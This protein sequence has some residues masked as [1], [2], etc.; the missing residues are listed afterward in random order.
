MRHISLFSGAG[1]SEWTAALL[2][3]ETV[4]YVEQDEYCQRAIRAR[5]ADGLF[6]AAPIFDD[7]RAVDWS[8]WAGRADIITA[9]F[10]CQPFSVAGSGKA[11][12]DPR[13]LW[14][15]TLRSIREVEPVF[16]FLENVPGLLAGS[17]GYFGTVLGELASIGFDAEWS[18]LSAKAA[19]APHKRK[20]L[21]VL[22]T[23]PDRFN[24][25]HTERWNRRERSA[26][27][28]ADASDDG[29]AQLVAYTNGE[30]ELQPQGAEQ[31]KRRRAGDGGESRAWCWP[32]EPG[33]G[34]AFDGL[35]LR[36]YGDLISNE[37][38]TYITEALRNVWENDAAQEV[39]E[40]STRRLGLLQAEDVLLAFVCEHSPG[41]RISRQLMESPQALEGALRELRRESLAGGAPHR[42]GQI[43]QLRREHRDAMRI[44]SHKIA[45][46]APTPWGNPL[47]EGFVDRASHGVANRGHRLRALGNGW[48]P[49]V[50]ALAFVGLMERTLIAQGVEV[51]A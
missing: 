45:S 29:R 3:W 17:H 27:A 41:G 20:R 33:M 47:W 6:C 49:R 32:T 18:C 12:D 10:P 8:Q 28:S 50:A 21:W 7:I 15:E 19:G 16:A 26:L 14:P 39:L 1:G 44:M 4:C 43:E 25:L 36:K 40:R 11:S 48:V 35:A 42:R 22:A 24:I 23:H 38:E 31:I 5:I 37:A 46:R 30:G 34:G 51:A 2:G 13:N 9:G